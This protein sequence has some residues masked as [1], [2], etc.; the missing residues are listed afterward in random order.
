MLA[1]VVGLQE[2]GLKE[3]ILLLL[4][5]LLLL[6][7]SLLLLLLFS[8]SLWLL[9]VLL[10]SCYVSMLFLIEYRLFNQV[11]FCWLP[12]LADKTKLTLEKENIVLLQLVL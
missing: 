1:S 2:Q 12:L 5:L 10:M 6:M 8:Q 3:I 9:I 7:L 11:S 4:L